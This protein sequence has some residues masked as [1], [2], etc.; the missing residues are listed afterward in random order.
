MKT[1]SLSIFFLTLWAVT[2]AQTDTIP[3]KPIIDR[4]IGKNEIKL[5]FLYALVGSLGRDMDIYFPEITY[6]RIIDDGF[7][8]GIS[9][10]RRAPELAFLITPHVR[11]YSGK[12]NNGLFFEFNA[13]ILKADYD[14]RRGHDFPHPVFEENPG[15]K[16][17]SGLGFA[18]GGKFLIGNGFVMETYLGFGKSTV[19][20]E[21]IKGTYSYPRAGITMGQRF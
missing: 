18:V 2:F 11:V 14:Y 12:K 5:N 1:L 17:G 3:E 10:W 9:A 13:A 16:L 4:T 19:R 7:T 8:V 6:E 21:N 15:K 20:H